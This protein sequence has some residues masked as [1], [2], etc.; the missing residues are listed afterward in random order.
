M[1]PGIPSIIVS[2]SRLLGLASRIAFLLVISLIIITG[3]LTQKQSLPIAFG[4]NAMPARQP[5]SASGG[6]LKLVVRDS[7][8]GFALHGEVISQ[9][10][11]GAGALW[12]NAKGQGNYLLV[13]GRN[14]L[15]IHAA[16]HK[17]LL[18][19]F[20]PD[21][22]SVKNVTLWVDPLEPP[23][24][25]RPEIIASK[26]RPGQALLH[27][28]VVD[29]ETGLPIKGAL[30]RLQQAGVKSETDAR[31]YF[32]LYGP[33]TPVNPI[34]EL[35]GSDNLI[36]NVKGFKT[37][38]RA[39]V[40]VAEG[41]THFII[42]MSPGA[43]VIKKDDTHKL[44]LSP[45]QLRNSQTGISEGSGQASG[46]GGRT[47]MPQEA[48][49]EVRSREV[50]N[51]SSGL[52]VPTSIR[53][54]SNCPSGRTSCTTF[55]VYS[56]DTYVGRGLDDEWFSSW[57]MESLKAGAIAYRSY[58]VWFVYNPISANYDICNTTSCQAHDPTDFSTRVINATDSTTGMIVTNSTG[59]GPFF[60]EYA[61]ENNNNACADGFT[62]S[63]GA[64]WPC[65]SDPV[66]AG[67]TFNGHGRGM[68]QWGTQRWA[69]NQGRD[70]VWIV[71]HYYNNNGSPSGARSGVLQTPAAPTPT[72][73]PTPFPPTPTPT[74]TP[75]QLLLD[76]SG[77]AVDQVAALD[78]VLFI[79]DPLPVVNAADLLNTGSD[80]NTR[81]ILFVTNLQLLPGETSS[82][83]VVNLIDVNN[84]AY[85]VPAE[86]VRPVPDSNFTQV[87]FRLPNNLPAGTCTLKISAHGQFSNAGTIRIRD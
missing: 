38:H 81:V 45:E 83:V 71:N 14:E 67:Q 24:E 34:D 63:P 51:Q 21:L 68:C 57:D 27:G 59:T 29:S 76:T 20:E 62:G 22:Q 69:V 78:S 6:S 72:P 32:L 64:N 86:D 47:L 23:D 74:P 70:Y 58:A 79:R 77:P 3:V 25:L 15:E 37:Y 1:N 54:G 80:K 13:N 30:V 42:D 28:H 39:N 33:V 19:H 75:P 52:V 11:N 36:V 60:A 73:S 48:T 66:D 18:T 87:I 2:R 12:T 56:L 65:L 82:A 85:D 61:A 26:L 41:A 5:S 4:E 44:K 46:V 43:G 50:V 10:N 49:A 84:Q 31:G 55:N 35:P 40:T 17:S 53:V 16:N 7:M 8:T 9:V